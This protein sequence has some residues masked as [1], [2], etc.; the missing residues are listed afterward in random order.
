MPERKPPS[1]AH[2]VPTGVDGPTRPVFRLLQ[3]APMSLRVRLAAALGVAALLPMVV[4]VA[5]PWLKAGT[6]A[7]EAAERRLAAATRQ[8]EALVA[9]DRDEASSRLDR[10]A[11]ILEQDRSALDAVLRGP[12]TAA[13]SVAG[14]IAEEASLEFAEV[15]AADGTVLSA[16]GSGPSAGELSLLGDVP[17]E[18]V[19][20]RRPPSAAGV[21]GDVVAWVGR[22]RVEARGETLWVAG[23]RRVGSDLLG[24]IAD[25][26]G[27]RAALLA[28]DGRPTLAAGSTP[29]AAERIEAAVPVDA[30]WSV[31]VRAAGGDL[32]K[33]RRDLLAAAAGVAPFA[34]AAAL[35][36][37]LVLG[38]SFSRRVR[39]LAARADAIAE[40][41]GGEPL[42][43]PS[44]GDEVRRLSRSFDR[45]LDALDASERRRLGAE[46]IAAWQEVARRVAHE[47]RNALSP[48]RL[49]VENLRR[50]REKSPGALATALDEETRT[51]LE[52]VDSLRRL[53]DTFSEFARLPDATR[54]PCD[55]ADVARRAVAFVAPR[56]E[57][58]EVTLDS[59][60][61]GVRLPAVADADQIGRVLKNVLGNALD[62][63]EAKTSGELRVAIGA[64]ASEGHAEIVI[65]DTGIGI[66]PEDLARVFEP[67]FTTRLE[68]GGT[69]LGMAIARRIVE[70][71][72]G[73]ILA[74]GAPG[75]G[76]TFTLRLPI[77]PAGH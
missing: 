24:A 35:I 58:L 69:G 27:E 3:S 17:D 63:L 65:S 55:L 15:A 32:E 74:E 56:A 37:A 11:E 38:E 4:A 36:L 19:A 71:H 34:L 53:V 16:Y 20:A 48:I 13:A 21:A 18:G 61:D 72:G 1:V 42:S 9:R 67:Y 52:E 47:V 75:K 77:D 30:G 76:A 49:A 43:Y 31:V 41:R 29:D 66:S 28:P 45:M 5:V 62:S 2:G 10:A 23:G 60:L 54:A 14:T 50:T 25:V 51:I 22:R 70:Q 33:V 59:E 40:E 46:R 44:E 6:T 8:A 57:T 73:E 7:K 39:A 26:T 12:A 68:R 64:R